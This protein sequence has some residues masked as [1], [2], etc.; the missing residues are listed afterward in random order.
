[1]T[2]RSGAE[3]RRRYDGDPIRSAVGVRAGR[4][5]DGVEQ[6]AADLLGEPVEVTDIAIVGHSRELGLDRVRRMSRLRS[7]V[8]LD[9]PVH[10]PDCEDSKNR[11][12][13]RVP[14]I[15]DAE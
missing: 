7:R 12:R 15:G 5:H 3:Q 9:L 13:K 6:V 11:Y 2:S 10:A 8:P 4:D 1:M 14:R